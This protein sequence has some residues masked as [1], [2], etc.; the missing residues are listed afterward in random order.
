MEKEIHSDVKTGKTLVIP[1]TPCN[2]AEHTDV[3]TNEYTA[4]GCYWPGFLAFLVNRNWSEAKQEIQ[5]R[6]YGGP[7]FPSGSDDK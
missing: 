4:L 2:I 1:L 7:C 3:Q 5:A 6:L